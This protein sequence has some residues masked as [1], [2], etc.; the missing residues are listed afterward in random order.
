MYRVITPKSNIKKMWVAIPPSTG[1]GGTGTN[2]KNI[3]IEI[4]LIIKSIY[5]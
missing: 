2:I 3:K 5:T 4:G 1:N